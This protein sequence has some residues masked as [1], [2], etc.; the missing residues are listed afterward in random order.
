MKTTKILC[1][2]LLVSCTNINKTDSNKD[3]ANIDPR[4]PRVTYNEDSF[5]KRLKSARISNISFESPVKIISS[6]IEGR[7][8]HITFRNSGKK[9]ITAIRF[10]W[11][12][13]NVFGESSIISKGQIAKSL[14]PGEK[15]SGTWDLIQRD[16]KKISK[17]EVAEIMFSDGTK[18]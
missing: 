4:I 14:G 10:Q 1:I 12:T 8:I 6:S 7:E 11:E 9:N 17:L 3:S 18:W 16:A 5:Q 2:F 13:I 15:D